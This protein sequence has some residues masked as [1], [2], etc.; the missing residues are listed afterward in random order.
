MKFRITR[1]WSEIETASSARVTLDR[2]GRWFVSFAAPPKPLERTSTAKSVGL[3]LGIALS[4][5][6]SNGE[7]LSMPQ[8]LSKGERKRCQGRRLARQTKGS[9]RRKLTKQLLAKISAREKDRRKDWIEKTTTK[10]VRDYDLIAIE[11]LKIKNMTRLA[12]GRVENPGKNVRAKSGLNRSILEQS[13][14]L[15]RKRLT[16]KA[17]N[18]TE[19]VEIITINPAYTSLRCSR[20]GHTDKENR[21]NQA[22]FCCPSC[23]YTANADVN[24]AK[25]ILAA[26]HAVKGRGGT[27][28][29]KPDRV[30]HNDPVK[31]Q[32]AEAA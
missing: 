23:G 12:Q 31:R 20:C 10:L 1:K 6:T 17:T 21:K 5:S 27:S 29:A 18:A 22:F 30:E 9:N 11:D 26:G 4:V 19:P 8:L 13:W 24:A 2:A 25:N 32:P 28:Q 7:M 14:G 16:D 15:S 3:D